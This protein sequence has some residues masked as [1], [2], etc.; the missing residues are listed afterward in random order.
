MKSLQILLFIFLVAVYAYAKPS[1]KI[2]APVKEDKAEYIKRDVRLSSYDGMIKDEDLNKVWCDK[3]FNY[4]NYKTLGVTKFINAP[5]LDGK[6]NR[7]FIDMPGLYIKR[8]LDRS[9]IPVKFE[10]IDI[11][12]ASLNV[13]ALKAFKEDLVLAGVITEIREEDAYPEFP[14]PARLSVEVVLFDTKKSKIIIAAVHSQEGVNLTDCLEHI[15][16]NIVNYLT[17]KAK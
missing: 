8:M 2:T 9:R 5:L 16:S 12:P 3:N 6:I 1:Q 11:E 15:T 7:D 17:R 10:L 4:K 14:A 13:K